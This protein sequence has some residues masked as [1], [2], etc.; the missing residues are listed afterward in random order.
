[1]ATVAGKEKIEQLYLILNHGTQKIPR[2]V[3]RDI[4]TWNKNKLVAGLNRTMKWIW[5]KNKQH[6]I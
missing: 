2:H 6:N 1:L 3:T 5:K 4:L